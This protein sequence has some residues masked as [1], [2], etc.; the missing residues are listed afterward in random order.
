MM[1][2]LD[3]NVISEPRRADKA[4]VKVRAWAAGQP[5]SDIFMS[6]ITILELELGI[7]RIE[8]KD[9]AQGAHAAPLAE[10]AS[11]ATI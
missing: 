7:L 8:R 5:V 3:T 2:L 4:D 9:P 6:A 1:F 10:R 11:A